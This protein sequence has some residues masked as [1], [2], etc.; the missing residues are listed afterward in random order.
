MEGSI[1]IRPREYLGSPVFPEPV[2]VLAAQPLGK[3]LKMAAVGEPCLLVG[4]LGPVAARPMG[5]P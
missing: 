2:R 3:S 4:T 5:C 1:C